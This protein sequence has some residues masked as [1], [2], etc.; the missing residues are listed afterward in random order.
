MRGIQKL[1]LSSMLAAAPAM[2]AP[3][4][5]PATSSPLVN[6]PTPSQQADAT[7]RILVLP[8]FDASGGSSY[9]WVGKAIQQDLVADLARATRAHLESPADA[10]PAA[11]AAA[12]LAAGRSGG[13]TLVIYGQ[14]QA[15]GGQMQITGQILSTATGQPGGNFSAAGAASDLFP[16]E[17][18]VAAQTL[19][20]LPPGVVTV[21][22]PP[23]AAEAS[24]SGTPAAAVPPSTPPAQI[25]VPSASASGPEYYSYTYPDY[26]NGAEPTYAYGYDDTP[27][28]WDAYPFYGPDIFFY[29]GGGWDHF[30]HYGGGYHGGFG[31]HFDEHGFHDFAG[32]PFGGPGFS[33][34][35]GAHFGG[36]GGFHGGGEGGHGGGGG[37][38]GGHGGR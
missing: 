11:D 14:Y 4:T 32:R 2:A 30:H 13:A 16:L 18:K 12:A 19:R 5:Q 31:G 26:V 23:T 7:D 35:S 10:A 1:A 3:A 33:H 15:A 25:A 22:L 38:G 21:A 17:D 34:G 24:A 36:G 37:G 9:A 28:L 27:Y 29:G 20:A 8:F 6:V